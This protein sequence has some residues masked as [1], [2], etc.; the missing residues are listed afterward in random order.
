MKIFVASNNV[1]KS[2]KL[3]G[4]TDRTFYISSQ[5]KI[6]D[7]VT[8]F[9]TQTGESDQDNWLYFVKYLSILIVTF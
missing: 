6:S 8:Y 7:L 1:A 9:H 3:F 4:S 2:Q 5:H